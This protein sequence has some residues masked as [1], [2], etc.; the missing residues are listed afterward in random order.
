M[1][2]AVF[3]ANVLVSGFPAASGTM[4]NLIDHWRAGI[5]QLVISDHIIAEVSRAWTKPYWQA[6]FSQVQVARAL[7]LLEQ[8]AD[9]TPITVRVV[10]IATHP[11]DDLV[12]AT[13]VSA[14]VDY[15]VTGDTRL[16][17]VGSYR[18]VVICSPR[19]FLDLLEREEARRSSEP[20]SP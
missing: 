10:G 19:A 17:D 4:A 9:V 12:L 2:R 1:I 14:R 7:V 18:G 20:L 5:F 13:A 11:E 3:D 6:R 8:E 15:L 16:R